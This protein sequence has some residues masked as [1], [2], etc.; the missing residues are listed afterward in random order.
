MKMPKG[1][2]KPPKTSDNVSKKEIKPTSKPAH[3]HPA[4]RLG[5]LGGEMQVGKKARGTC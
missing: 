4:D 2:G 5:G 1:T 3:K